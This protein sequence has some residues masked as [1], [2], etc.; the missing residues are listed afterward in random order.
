MTQKIPFE[1][2]AGKKK[3]HRRNERRILFHFVLF[4]ALAVLLIAAGIYGRIQLNKISEQEIA[5]SRQSL[6]V[7]ETSALMKS[8]AEANAGSQQERTKISSGLSSKSRS[9]KSAVADMIQ[10]GQ[11]NQEIVSSIVD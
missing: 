10:A 2:T 5:S 7:D 1:K 4:T 6:L 11:S 9:I 3:H 8:A